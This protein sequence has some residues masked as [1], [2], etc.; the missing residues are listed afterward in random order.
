MLPDRIGRDRLGWR[1]PYPTRRCAS[2]SPAAET[3]FDPAVAFDDISGVVID[4]ILKAMLD[5]DY[6][7]RPVKLVPRTLEAMPAVEDGG[8]TYVCKVRKGIFFAPD[9]VF[10]GKPRELTAA[11]HAYGLKAHPRPRRQIAL[12]LDAR[13]QGRR[14]GRSACK[15]GTGP[16]SSITTRPL[17]G[18]EVIDRYTLKIRLKAP[19]LRFLYMLAVPNTAA[20]AEKWSRRTAIDIGAHPVGTGPY[21]LWTIPAQCPH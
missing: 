6:L 10:K 11:D 21:M 5:Y 1:P 13:R 3:S 14:C 17:P 19:D 8:T 9:P 2:L 16:A 4:S 20:M 18:L 12:A 7:A 15:G